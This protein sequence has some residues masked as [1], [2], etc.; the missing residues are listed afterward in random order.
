MNI[1]KGVCI[2]GSNKGQYI[3]SRNKY[4]DIAILPGLSPA[5]GPGEQVGE[6]TVTTEEYRFYELSSST[7][8]WSCEDPNKI[9]EDFQDYMIRTLVEGFKVLHEY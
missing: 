7:G 2:D 9:Y 3:V 8:V 6:D 5:V 4:Y 1:F